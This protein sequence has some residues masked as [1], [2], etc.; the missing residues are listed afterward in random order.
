MK[1][2]CGVAF[3]DVFRGLEI[4][5]HR[6]GERLVKFCEL[7]QALGFRNLVKGFERAGHFAL[8]DIGPGDH[9]PVNQWPDATLVFDP[10]DQ[11]VEIAIG[12]FRSRQDRMGDL[13]FESVVFHTLG[14]RQGARQFPGGK[15]SHGG[16]FQQCGIAGIGPKCA[17]IVIDGR[18][19]IAA[20]PGLTR[21]QIIAGIARQ[22]RGRG[23][24]QCQGGNQSRQGGWF[25]PARDLGHGLTY[26][27]G[28]TGS[29]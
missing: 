18:V 15:L 16:A 11:R 9:Q 12:E 27:F 25:C 7:G 1:G 23:Q 2:P 21:G 14:E 8:A 5:D 24:G 29:E 3:I 19:V 22:G 10:F 28:A 20:K 4:A 26:R 13:A 6:I 17:D